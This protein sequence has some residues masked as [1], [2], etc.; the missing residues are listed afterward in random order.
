[1][2]L[3]WLNQSICLDCRKTALSLCP[4][5]TRG[6]DQMEWCGSPLAQVS[7]PWIW[8][9]QS[10]ALG[11]YH[12]ATTLLSSWNSHELNS[13]LLSLMDG[14]TTWIHF[15]PGTKCY[16]SLSGVYLSILGQSA[17]RLFADFSFFL[18]TAPRLLCHPSGDT[19]LLVLLTGTIQGSTFHWD[20]GLYS[21]HG[22]HGRSRC[23]GWE[24]ARSR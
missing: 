23:P 12:R 18:L 24:T 1:M 22:L 17:S 15:Q 5:M 20:R 10:G 14:I 3:K 7:F 11:C 4:L 6:E 2:N 21:G 16:Y 9:E 13:P 8:N 19:A